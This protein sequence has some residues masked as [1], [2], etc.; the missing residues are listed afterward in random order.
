LAGFR[1]EKNFGPTWGGDP[2][3]L[4]GVSWGG[5]GP[6]FPVFKISLVKAN[7]GGRRGPGGRQKK[8]KAKKKKKKKKGGGLP[9][10]KGRIGG[11]WRGTPIV[12]MVGFG[13]FPSTGPGGCVSIW[14]GQKKKWGDPQ[15]NTKKKK[16]G[17]GGGGKTF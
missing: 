1:G 4:R 8:K 14:L 2:E 6:F 17:G 9:R 13:R 12:L 10:P 11:R 5:G 16:K 7:F 3:K 15:R